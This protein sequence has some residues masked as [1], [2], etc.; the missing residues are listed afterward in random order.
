MFTTLIK[1]D[2]NM[3]TFI[4][5]TEVWE[6]NQEKTE[7]TLVKG[8][9]GSFTEFEKYSQTMSF[10]YDEGLPGKAWSAKHP[11][12]LKK[13][14]GSYFQRTEMAKEIGLTTAIAMPIF[15]GEYLHAVVLFL[16]G[17]INEHAGAIELWKKEENRSNEMGLV[18]GYYGTME[19]FEWLSSRLKIM[20][21]HGLPGTV[22]TSKMPLVIKN[23]SE[24][25]T[26]MRAAKAAKEGITTALA[27]PAWMYEENA[28]VMTFLS[29]KGTP[30]ARRFEVWVPVADE[31][32]LYF[33]DGYCEAGTDLAQLYAE[34]T[35][36]KYSS[37][38]GEVW[39]TGLPMLRESHK[40]DDHDITYSGSLILP[41][42]QNGFCKAVVEF[43]F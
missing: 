25:G 15:A 13:L 41:I 42:I 34:S 30:I 39:K 29:A 24:S 37:H 1:E 17:D 18:D 21:G 33:Q 36:G 38:T 26:F 27:L 40:A 20:K 19:K 14:E 10:K 7:L 22:W 8:L 2:K 16:C 12:I 3:T 31:D 32:T 11:I 35:R 23:L 4:K 6:P 43:Y 28:Y 9:Y 5:A